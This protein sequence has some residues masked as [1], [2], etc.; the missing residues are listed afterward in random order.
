MLPNKKSSLLKTIGRVLAGLVV[1]V[2]ILIVIG[3]LLAPDYASRKTP[4]GFPIN[5]TYYLPLNE[6]S[7]V[8][9]SVWLPPSLKNDERIPA[10]MTTSRYSGQLESGWLAKVLQTY[11]GRPDPNFRGARRLL[12]KGFAFVWVQSPGSC[13][14]SGPRLGEYPPNEVDAMGLAIDWIARQPWSN[15][16]VGAFG[17]SYSGT[18]AD[19]ACATQRPELKAVYSQGS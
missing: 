19:M 4:A 17:A 2:I 7:N 15:Q 3:I 12:D 16:R 18:T 14:S 11:F 9:I 8:W 13:Q 1:L 10:L 6:K 5:A